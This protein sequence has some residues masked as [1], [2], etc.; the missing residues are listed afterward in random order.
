MIFVFF[1][2]DGALG[3][4]RPQKTWD[5]WIPQFED[6]NLDFL[7][8]NLKS[9]AEELSST[10][11]KALFDDI[12]FYFHG[13]DSSCPYTRANRCDIKKGKLFSRNKCD[14][15]VYYE[16]CDFEGSYT[17]HGYFTTLKDEI[18]QKPEKLLE[19]KTYDHSYDDSVIYAIKNLFPGVTLEFE[20]VKNGGRR[21]CLPT[22]WS[23]P[24]T[25]DPVL[26]KGDFQ[27]LIFYQL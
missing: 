18:L 6:F 2:F 25:C 7:N 10:L 17:C 13:S 8:I 3:L 22:A 9:A 12:G 14:W 11:S 16:E 4:P 21:S 19:W 15:L 27:I 1:L 20:K 26:E 23:G 24:E 5:D